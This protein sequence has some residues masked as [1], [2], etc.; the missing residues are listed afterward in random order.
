MARSYQRLELEAYGARVPVIASWL[1]SPPT[2]AQLET[3]DRAD[4]KAAKRQGRYRKAAQGATTF[5]TAATAIAALD[6]MGVPLPRWI[7][8][9]QL[10]FVL[11]SVSAVLWISW[12]KLLDRWMRARAEAED[13]RARLFRALVRAPA[14]TGAA[15]NR[16]LADQLDAFVTCHLEYQR[17]YYQRRSGDHANAAGSVAPLKMLGYAIIAVSIVV[18]IAGVAITAAELGWIGHSGWMDGLRSLPIS[19]PHRLQLGLGTLASA[20]LSF[21]AAWTL[22]NQDDRN[23]ARYAMTAAKL[24]AAKSEGLAAAQAAALA[25]DRQAVLAFTDRVQFILDAEHS[26]WVASRP[27]EDPNAGPGPSLAPAV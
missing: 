16:A 15:A 23:A 2:V 26:A 10:L 13:E 8:L 4:A 19:E 20:S 25:G 21:A 11:A 22:I 1:E 27:P 18:G 6:L 5:T 12:H 17:G 9:V 3:F 24:T 14:P 7:G